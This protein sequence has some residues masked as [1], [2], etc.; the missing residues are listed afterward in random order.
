M[1]RKIEKDMT[2]AEVMDT[3]PDAAFTLMNMGLMCGGCPMAQFETVEQG[4]MMHG[5]DADEVV[6]K[7]NEKKEGTPKKKDGRK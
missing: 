2:F 5:V 7:L 1:V 6:G 3:D 4:C